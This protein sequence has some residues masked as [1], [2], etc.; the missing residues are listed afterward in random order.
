MQPSRVRPL[1]ERDRA[2]IADLQKWG[3]L[4]T[5]EVGNRHFDG[6]TAARHRLHALMQRSLVAHS[7]PSPQLMMW[8]LTDK[9]VQHEEGDSVEDG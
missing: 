9:G 7:T 1:T 4:S 3:A 6:F 8:T 2:I 5:A